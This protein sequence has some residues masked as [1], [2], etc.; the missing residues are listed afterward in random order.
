MQL[1]LNSPPAICVTSIAQRHKSRCKERVILKNW[2]EGQVYER[3]SDISNNIQGK[4]EVIKGA[5]SGL[6]EATARFL[7]AQG[8]T[9]V[10]GA[11]RSD[12]DC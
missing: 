9:V 12:H 5:S 3:R 7:S 11:R 1:K 8:A 10:L 6:R 2:S 4:V